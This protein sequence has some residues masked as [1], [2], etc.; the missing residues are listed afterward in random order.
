MSEKELVPKE[1]EI[2]LDDG[3]ENMPPEVRHMMR[4]MSVTMRSGPPES[5]I[6]KHITPDHIM[7]TI[8]NE[9]KNDSRKFWLTVIFVIASL[10]TLGFVILMF[11]NAPEV[12]IPILTLLFGGGLG[13][14]GGY[15]IGKSK[16]GD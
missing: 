4:A 9:G 1:D 11:R 14:G 6:A 16:R 2:S 7:K 10:L 15:G 12:L 5:P 13:F 8:E 3:M